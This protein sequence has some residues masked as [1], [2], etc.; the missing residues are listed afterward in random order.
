MNLTMAVKRTV[1]LYYQPSIEVLDFYL[2]SGNDLFIKI[3][4]NRI[5]IDQ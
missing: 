3:R 2:H 4:N 1:E 5:K